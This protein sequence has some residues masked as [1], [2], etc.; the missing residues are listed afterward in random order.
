MNNKAALSS[1]ACMSILKYFK[2]ID[3]ESLSVL[4]NPK[5]PLCMS[6]SSEAIATA[7]K[8]VP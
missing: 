1:M 2:L 6:L 8:R 4:P 7:S 5:G 3:N